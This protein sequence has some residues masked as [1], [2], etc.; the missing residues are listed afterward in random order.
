MLHDKKTSTSTIH[1]ILNEKIN[2]LYELKYEMSAQDQ[3]IFHIPKEQ[4]YKMSEHQKQK[5]IDTTTTTV[6]KCIEEHQQK[7]AQG[8]QDIRKYFNTQKDKS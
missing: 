6:Y 4:R 7:M 1:Q 2:N 5:W 3:D 8:Q